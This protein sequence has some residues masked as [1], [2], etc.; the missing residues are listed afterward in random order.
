[1]AVFCRNERFS[2]GNNEKG[3]IDSLKMKKKVLV[4]MSGGVDS[5]VSASLLKDQGY[6]VV[7][8]TLQVWD[9]S[10]NKSNEGYGTCCSH[11]D[12]QDARS[13]CDILGIPFYVLNSE[14]LFE[15][16]VIKP[17]VQDYLNAKT[18]IPCLNCN[19][20]L[21]F[22]YLI[23]KMEELDCDFLATGHY[24]KVQ[25]LKNG[26]YGLFTSSNSVKDQSYFLFT[27]KP[28]ILPRLLFPV[29]SMNKE[30]VRKIAIKKALPVFQ[31]KD[32]TGICF[33]GKNS[34]K[35]FVQNYVEDNQLKPAKKGLLKHFPTGEI[36][37][38]HNGIHNFTIG[39]RKGLGVCFNSPLFV[40]KIDP[41][42]QEVW[43]GK[44]DDLYSHSAEV[45]DVH[46]L[47][48]ANSGEKL[49]VKT[50]FHDEG[51]PAYIYK[52]KE[53]YLLKFLQPKKAITPGQSAVFY[54]D[55]QILGGG[56]IQKSLNS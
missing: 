44:E 31:K 28:E 17:F 50:R 46:W 5:S 29:G 7:G 21:K 14:T 6:E 2:R 36:L 30:E 15:K 38:E 25:K 23:K 52:K 47:D 45:V 35:D 51:A 24:A 22:H 26:K 12:V 33:V 49:H 54:R 34:Y 11:V 32:S 56:V 48:P 55:K 9:Y 20:F 37:A 13:V 41:Q 19:T 10:K 40:I 1:M 53:H 8:A 42:T 39:Q 16:T 18:P 4:A 43:L 27:L 3:R